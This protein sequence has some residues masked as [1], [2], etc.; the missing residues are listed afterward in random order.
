MR[1]TIKNTINGKVSSKELIVKVQYDLSKPIVKKEKDKF[2]R[3]VFTAWQEKITTVCAH[4][5]DPEKTD[6][7][8]T[9]SG[10]TVCDYHDLKHYSKKY[11]KKL[12]W[13]NCINEMVADGAITSD[14]ADALDCI[15][16]NATSFVL[17]MAK[18]TVTS[19]K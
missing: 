7:R 2:G 5:Y 11:G 6:S 12:A 14:E 1:I 17:D 8:T 4:Y 18:K 15:D 3:F 16:L 9:W 19:I 13:L 10:Q